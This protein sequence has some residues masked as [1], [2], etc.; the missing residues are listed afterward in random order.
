MKYMT[1]EG[2]FVSEQKERDYPNI[3]EETWNQIDEEISKHSEGE[4]RHGLILKN[5]G[6]GGYLFLAI[7]QMGIETGLTRIEPYN[8][9]QE[10]EDGLKHL[11]DVD[12]WPGGISRLTE[13]FCS[14]RVGVI[15]DGQLVCP[16]GEV[17]S[18]DKIALGETIIAHDPLYGPFFV[19]VPNTR[20]EDSS[21]DC[22]AFG[23]IDDALDFIDNKRWK[24]SEF[25]GKYQKGEEEHVSE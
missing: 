16:T 19:G 1:K 14:D 8:C 25:M 10:A 18:E 4:L 20:H 2:E 17:V 6:E 23:Y 21:F 24:D 3:S 22:V 5:F 15:K 13:E 9:Y 11:S 7:K 12:G